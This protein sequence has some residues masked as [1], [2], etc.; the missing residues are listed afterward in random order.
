MP[1]LGFPAYGV[2]ICGLLPVACCRLLFFFV[3]YPLLLTPYPFLALSSLRPFV[4]FSFV[5]IPYPLHHTPYPFFPYPFF[6]WTYTF[7]NKKYKFRAR[8]S[9]SLSR[10]RAHARNSHSN[11]LV[12]YFFS[13][14]KEDY[15]FQNLASD[16]LHQTTV[17]CRS[18][19]HL[20]VASSK[21]KTA[22]LSSIYSLPVSH[23]NLLSFDRNTQILNISRSQKSLII[24]CIYIIL[25]KN[26]FMETYI[27]VTGQYAG[28]S[29]K[30]YNKSPENLCCRV[31][32]QSELVVDSYCRKSQQS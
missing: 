11:H 27:K 26:I 14:K 15:F 5:F 12:T 3:P 22:L 7:L 10:A 2:P 29:G 25:N 9:L 17:F 28:F 30:D 18:K 6:G 16:F 19:Q 13:N 24:D 1:F 31:P 23:K 20:Y 21:R 4:L 32:R 8:V